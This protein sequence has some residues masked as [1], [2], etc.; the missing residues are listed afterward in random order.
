MHPLEDLFA[1]QDSPVGVLRAARLRRPETVVG[2]RRFAL[3]VGFDGADPAVDAMMAR[4][5]AARAQALS[6]AEAVFETYRPVV[7][8]RLGAVSAA[9]LTSAAA[10]EDGAGRGPLLRFE[11]P[12]AEG[13]PRVLGP[14]GADEIARGEPATG[15]LLRVRFRAEPVFIASMAVAGLRLVLQAARFVEP[16]EVGAGAER[17]ARGWGRAA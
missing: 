6:Q 3:R 2:G 1:P 4:L 14:G 17:R 13:A 10:G 5:E 15:R 12:V 8:R 16:A 9:P 7:R 11:R